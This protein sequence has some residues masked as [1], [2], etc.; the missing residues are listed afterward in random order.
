MVHRRS[1]THLGSVV[2][3]LVVAPTV[4]HS[5]TQGEP[6]ARADSA[7][8]FPFSRPKPLPMCEEFGIF[9]FG[10]GYRLGEKPSWAEENLYFVW[11]LGWMRNVNKRMALG[12]SLFAGVDL[13]YGR[14]GVKPRY[15]LWLSSDVSL[16]VSAGLFVFGD[17]EQFA[18]SN[19]GFTGHVGLNF[20]DWFQPMLQVDVVR[21]GSFGTDVAWYAGARVGRYA[22]VAGTVGLA[23]AIYLLLYAISESGGFDPLP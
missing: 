5:Q 4:A 21:L 1:I 19:P 6:T 12:L 16:D 8:A 13:S 9:E 23:A 17:H 2:L 20:A 22:A 7:C 18:V 3:A 10:Y 11:D 15:R 14:L